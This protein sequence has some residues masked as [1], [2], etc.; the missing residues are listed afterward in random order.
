MKATL[1]DHVFQ[2]CSSVFPL[3]WRL[4][5]ATSSKA[6]RSRVTFPD[7]SQ[8][9]VSIQGRMDPNPEPLVLA[10]SLGC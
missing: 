5:M 1:P 8:E 9:L 3:G 10:Y 7:G 6:H 2:V 4:V